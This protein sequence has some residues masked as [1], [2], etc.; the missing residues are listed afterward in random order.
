MVILI[1]VL[2]GLAFGSFVTALTW[3]LHEHKNFVTG[4]SQCEGCGH[5]L[6]AW[7]LIPLFSWLALRGRC[8]YCKAKVSWQNPVIEVAMV[9]LFVGSYLCWPHTLDSL[10]AIATFALWLVYIVFLMAMLVYDMRWMLLPDALVFPLIVLGF[11]DAALRLGQTGGLTIIGYVSYIVL[12]AAALGGFYWLLNAISHGRW[13]GFG[14]VKLGL[15]MGIVLGWQQ[16][17]LVLFVANLIGC[18]VALPALASG[19]LSVKSRLPFG[20][21]LIVAFLIVGLFGSQLISW[22]M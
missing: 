18:L 15:F 16:A 3:R 10:P 17:L 8:R 14:D 20:P 13:V 9:V 4:R 6:G 12:G 19:K 5:T 11:V 7:D 22:Y 2:L 21:F 1:L